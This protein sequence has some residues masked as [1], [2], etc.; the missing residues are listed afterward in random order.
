MRQSACIKGI[1][2][3]AAAGRSHEVHTMQLFSVTWHPAPLMVC[4]IISCIHSIWYTIVC[5]TIQN[6]LHDYIVNP[7]ERYKMK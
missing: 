5:I 3:C 2:L 1:K 6:S 7:K 4:C